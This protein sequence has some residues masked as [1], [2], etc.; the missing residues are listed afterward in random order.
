MKSLL[1]ADTK[2]TLLIQYYF[3]KHLSLIV[4]LTGKKAQASSLFKSQLP[5]MVFLPFI[6]YTEMD[7]N[8]LGLYIP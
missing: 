6:M 1:H 4:S 3:E 2:V 7:V 8:F 5:M